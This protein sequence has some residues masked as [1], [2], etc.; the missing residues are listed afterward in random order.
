MKNIAQH[1]VSIQL[2]WT[3]RISIA[4][5]Y[6]AIQEQ[7]WLERAWPRPTPTPL[8]SSSLFWSISLRS[9][10]SIIWYS[11]HSLFATPHI[12][13]WA[14]APSFCAVEFPIPGTQGIVP[15]LSLPPFYF[16]WCPLSLG[17]QA[18]KDSCSLWPCLQLLLRRRAAWFSSASSQDWFFFLYPWKSCR[19][20]P[21]VGTVSA[22]CPWCF[23]LGTLCTWAP[24]EW[25]TPDNNPLIPSD[26][27]S[28][29]LTLF[30]PSWVPCS[31]FSA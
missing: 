27:F 4:H 19:V 6:A 21:T 18:S 8:Q 16:A 15:C 1:L 10:M 29:Y 22:A 9:I 30:V 11:A 24:A 3:I 5:V 20:V 23:C 12:S 13:L 28:H 2:V 14:Q 26:C 7:K 25:H 17:I 31:R